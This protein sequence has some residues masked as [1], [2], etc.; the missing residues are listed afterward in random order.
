[1]TVIMVLSDF[2]GIL[3]DVE[4]LRLAQLWGRIHHPQW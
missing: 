4:D 2:S 1:M 3:D